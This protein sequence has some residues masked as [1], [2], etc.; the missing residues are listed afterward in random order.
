MINDSCSQFKFQQFAE[1]ESQSDPLDV[2][3]AG[4]GERRPIHRAAGSNHA[5]IIKF[6][7]GK[8]AIVDQVR[9]RLGLPRPFQLY[10][11]RGGVRLCRL[12]FTWV[13]FLL[14]IFLQP[15]KS[16]RTAMHWAA[17]GGHTAAGQALAD[18]GAN[19]FAVTT[20]Q[21]SVLHASSEAGRA[22]FSDFLVKRAG[23]K[24][25]ELFN[26]RDASG[27]LAIELATMVPY[28]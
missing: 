15:D 7:I 21:M 20:S 16:L 26:A 5:D 3:V 23:D 11:K 18:A 2:N 27:K 19:L 14:F 25:N 8:G 10:T 13:A 12:I 6:L 24:K 1:S 22:G 17:I 28:N 9:Q 4:A